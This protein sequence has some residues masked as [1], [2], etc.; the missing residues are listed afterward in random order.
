MK[1][2]FWFAII[3]FAVLSFGLV[4]NGNEVGVPSPGEE[5]FSECAFSADC[6]KNWECTNNKCTIAFP[7]EDY[8]GSQKVLSHG[9]PSFWKDPEMQHMVQAGCS[10]DNQCNVWMPESFSGTADDITCCLNGGFC[11]ETI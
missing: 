6:Q 4:M 2:E 1:Q 5:L 10:N 9:S 11:Y 3:A 7:V 8:C